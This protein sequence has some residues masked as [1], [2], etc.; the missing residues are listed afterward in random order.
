[1]AGSDG[2]GTLTKDRLCLMSNAS[3]FRVSRR[4]YDHKVL[5]QAD[6]LVEVTHV[7]CL[8]VSICRS[9]VSVGRKIPCMVSPKPA[10]SWSTWLP[11]L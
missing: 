5:R 8:G 9:V 6:E 2:G 7:G 11:V 10:N 4:G 1:M 3:K